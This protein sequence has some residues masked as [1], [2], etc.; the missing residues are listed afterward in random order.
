[1]FVVDLQ[2]HVESVPLAEPGVEAQRDLVEIVLAVH[3][4]VGAFG[5][6]LTQQA[7]RVFVAAA[8]PGAARVGKVDHHPGTKGQ[9]RV[10]LALT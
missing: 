7:V 3:R 6:V 4:K 1:M 5:Q 2:R 8:L 10:M 9:R